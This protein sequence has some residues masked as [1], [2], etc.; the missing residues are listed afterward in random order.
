MVATVEKLASRDRVWLLF[1]APKV[2]TKVSLPVDA[3]TKLPDECVLVLLGDAQ[4]REAYVSEIKSKTASLELDDR[5][6]LPGHSRNVPTALMAADIII[7][8]STDPEAFGRV[9]A[10]AQAMGKPIIATAHGGALETVID[11]KTGYLVPPADTNSLAQAIQHALNWT[12]YDAKAA[13]ERIKAHFSKENL[14]LKT[15]SVY[16]DLLNS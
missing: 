8:A 14:Q 15:L 11:G 6:I 3:L 2:V 16:K 13:R 12:N 7:S 4:G 5:V 10:E 9:A 1:D